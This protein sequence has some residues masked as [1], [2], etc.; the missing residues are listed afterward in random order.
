M[1][2][3]PHSW[4]CLDLP[5][6]EYREALSLQHGVAAAKHR[7]PHMPDLVLLLEHPPVFTL[8][9]RGGM[10]NLTVDRRVLEAEGI[11][12]VQAERGGN[13]TY[14]GPG[15]LVAY[16]IVDLKRSGLKV[17]EYVH[18]LE[19]VMISI[20][21]D[22]GV[23]ASR[24]RLNR[25]IWVEGKKIGSI[26]IT[27]RRGICFHGF[28]LN[29][30]LS[31]T[32]FEWIHPCGLAGVRVTSMTKE[33]VTEVGMRRVRRSAR[34]HLGKVFGVEMIDTEMD[35]LLQ[36]PAFSSLPRPSTA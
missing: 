23:T 15:Q 31:L 25:G 3:K 24:N 13:I 22:F 14:H 10:E 36:L 6:T 27:V 17:V 35:E 16:P 1:E 9:R 28:A 7:H 11:S 19:T 4:R 33:G 29:V 5:A 30:D 8:G 2:S 26:G 12:V 21:G 20:A 34:S 32:P 18:A